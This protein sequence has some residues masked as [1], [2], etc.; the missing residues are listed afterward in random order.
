M[1]SIRKQVQE[2]FVRMFFREKV[3][4]KEYLQKEQQENEELSNSNNSQPNIPERP[5]VRILGRI[6]RRRQRIIIEGRA[7]IEKN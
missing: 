6:M 7:P 1:K 3:K 4:K 5:K 2:M